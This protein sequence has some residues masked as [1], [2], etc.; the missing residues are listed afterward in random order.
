L[1]VLFSIPQRDP[2]RLEYPGVKINTIEIIESER[3]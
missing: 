3:E 2:I 1:D